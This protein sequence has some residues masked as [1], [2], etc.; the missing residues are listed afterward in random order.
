LDGFETRR[1]QGL[2]AFI[3]EKDIAG[4]S[5]PDLVSILQGV[6][7]IHI[8]YRGTGKVG[9]PITPVPYMLGVG[10]PGSGAYCIPSF[11]LDRMPFDVNSGIDFRD[12][13]SMVP[14]VWIKGIEVYSSPGS[15]PME[16]DRS[17]STGCG[18]IVIWTR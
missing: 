14:P 7:G 9:D 5:F 13:S 1:K 17:S 16:Y 11:F 8:Q 6:R 18:S 15:T 4:H 10:S 3:A 12:L 2:G